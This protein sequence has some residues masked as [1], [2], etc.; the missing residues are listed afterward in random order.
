MV[1]RHTTQQQLSDCTRVMFSLKKNIA[2]CTYS[3]LTDDFY[4][5]FP[6]WQKGKLFQNYYTNDEASA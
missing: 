6:L 5:V 3:H 2:D 1:L 4:Q